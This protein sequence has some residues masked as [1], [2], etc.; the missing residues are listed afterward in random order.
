MW[1]ARGCNAVMYEREGVRKQ[2]R[3]EEE[4]E[5]SGREGGRGGA[6]GGGGRDTGG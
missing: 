3:G 1:W 6:R 5:V 4:R 2:R